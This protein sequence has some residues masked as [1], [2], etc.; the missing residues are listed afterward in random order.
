MRIACDIVLT[1]AERRTLNKWAAGRSATMSL[2]RR[3]LMILQ[4]A[5]GRTN[6]EIAVALR[7]DVH[8][9]GRWRKQFL[10]HRLK[11]IMTPVRAPG[12]RNAQA[13]R[14]ARRILMKTQEAPPQGISGWTSRSLARELGVS[15]SMIQRVWKAAGINVARRSILDSRRV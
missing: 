13:Q 14:W 12:L 7:A 5:S 10:V 3:A 1:T 9:V 11:G 4:A 6:R 15:H 2:S 8:T